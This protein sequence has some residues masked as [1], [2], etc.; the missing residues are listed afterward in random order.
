MVATQGLLYPWRVRC[1]SAVSSWRLERATRQWPAL[2]AV[3]KPI[4]QLVMLERNM[5][6]ND[7]HRLI[8]YV[9]DAASALLIS[10]HG[11]LNLKVSTEM[12]RTL[13]DGVAQRRDVLVDL[14]SVRWIDSS[15]VANLVEA[16]QRARR[17]GLGFALV[18]AHESVVQTL[19]MA[20]L[21]KVFNMVDSVADGQSQMRIGRL[22]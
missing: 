11:E 17:S 14:S 10:F 6:D 3:N 2:Q 15:G 22:H 19:S 12:R 4:D 16:F 18:G 5:S 21:D 7:H 20:N 9:S 1:D 8:G 13:L